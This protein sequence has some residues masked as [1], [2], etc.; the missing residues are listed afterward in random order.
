MEI[1]AEVKDLKK[2]YGKGENVIRAVDG[3]SLQ[4]EKGK[5][6]MIIGT[7][8]SGKTT[9]LNLLGGQ[10]S[11]TEGSITVDGVRID[12]MKESA[13][14]V[15]RRNK[16]GFIYQ[17]FNLIPM[18]NVRE[19]ILFSLDMGNQKPDMGFFQEIVETLHLE[20]KLE[21][22]PGEL[23]GGQRQQVAIARALM[24]RPSLV[25]ADEPTGN[26]DT[27]SSQNVLGL[28][29]LMNEKYHQT[30]VMITHNLDIV[31]MADKVIRIE[32]GKILS[33]EDTGHV[34]A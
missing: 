31:Q 32:D 24:G 19:N 4:I 27:K 8:G 10:D 15:Y 5:F 26:L 7:S 9:L 12:S 3:I 17:N 20:D 6:T 23:S 13:R 22:F 21:A 25:L 34:P 33:Q 29:K 28:L 30:L 2:Y 14:A 16:I 18:L 1:I 11:P